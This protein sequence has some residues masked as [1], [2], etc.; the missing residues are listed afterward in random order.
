MNT[1]KQIETWINRINKFKV[2]NRECRITLDI[3]KT[4]SEQIGKIYPIIH[5]EQYKDVNEL[6]DLT[7]QVSKLAQQKREA[8]IEYKKLME[9]KFKDFKSKYE[10]IF[11]LAI[12]EEGI[13]RETLEHVLSVYVDFKNDQLSQGQATNRGID[14]MK[15]KFNLK[16]DFLEH[17]EE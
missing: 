6:N 4:T 3:I 5:N 12:S 2:N 16:D 10:N 14:F 17:V 7:F 11:N 9:T 15:Q 13:D 8:E 1:A